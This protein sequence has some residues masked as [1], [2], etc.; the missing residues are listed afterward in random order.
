M[1]PDELVR[2]ADAKRLAAVALTD[3]D[4]TS[5]LHEAV[6]AA[7]ELDELCF[8]PGIEVSAE[9]AS[10]TMHLL[11]LDIDPRAPALVRLADFLR[12]ARN[13][14]NP[15]M[16]ARLQSLG[17]DVTM[18][19]VL[20]VAGGEKGKSEGDIVGRLH[21]AE[22]IRR[23]GYVRTTKEA[24]SRY[25]GRGAPGYA[26]K[27]RLEPAAIIRAIRGSGGIAALAHPVQLACTD[28]REL[29]RI[30]R[31]LMR[32]GLDGIEVYHTDHTAEQT[33]QYL[34]LAR[35]CG[36]EVTGGSDYHGP[37]KPDARLGV[38]RVPLAALGGEIA[39]RIAA[40]LAGKRQNA[41]E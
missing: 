14:R 31:E 17:L 35:T 39:R 5:G 29:E 28:A 6:M 18:D 23:K 24:F 19:D 21:M 26:D 37:A 36:L 22:T 33:R 25:V 40:G 2:H 41:G 20:A 34:E 9:F 7:R 1:A 16:I 8:I 11:G 10:G 3:H 12:E 27:R 38:P 30:V 4:T 13:E 32:E 15:R